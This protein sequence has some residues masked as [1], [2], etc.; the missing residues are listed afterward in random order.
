MSDHLKIGELINQT[1]LYEDPRQLHDML[2]E[3]LLVALRDCEVFHQSGCGLT[4][5]S[6]SQYVR[7]EKS[8]AKYCTRLKLQVAG[9]WEPGIRGI[10]TYGVELAVRKYENVR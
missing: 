2:Q 1:A 8:V 5:L 3:L 6:K 4:F 9:E 10:K 7:R